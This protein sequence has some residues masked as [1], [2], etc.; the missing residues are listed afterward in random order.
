MHLLLVF[1]PK[2]L[3]ACPKPVAAPASDILRAIRESARTGVTPEEIIAKHKHREPHV[4]TALTLNKRTTLPRTRNDSSVSFGINYNVRKAPTVDR[5]SNIVSSWS[6][7]VTGPSHYPL[8]HQS[9]HPSVVMRPSHHPVSVTQQ[10][11][12][13]VAVNA[14]PRSDSSSSTSSACSYRTHSDVDSGSLREKVIQLKQELKHC[15]E[16]QEE[17]QQKKLEANKRC[18]EAKRIFSE[19]HKKLAAANEKLE[20]VLDKLDKAEHR[21]LYLERRK[22]ENIQEKEKLEKEQLGE[23]REIKNVQYEI[24]EAKSAKE[25]TLQRLRE[26][27]QRVSARQLALQRAEGRM[28]ARSKRAKALED[29]IGSFRMKIRNLHVNKAK[30]LAKSEDQTHRLHLLEH[31]IE[32][33]EERS[34]VAEGRL[35]PL[36]IYTNQLQD[37]VE[38]RRE[39]LSKAQ[40][41]L[42]SYTQRLRHYRRYYY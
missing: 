5:N 11:Q 25:L 39:S 22:S 6:N 12:Q 26:V 38:E 13:P 32:Y 28:R 4:N 33:N 36:K 24:T 40:R 8:L 42:A 20:R 30:K 10:S 31:S 2:S 34:R 15:N 18:Q 7:G 3:H 14:R 41:Q 29:V 27:S 16:R 1:Q 23:E 9:H 35:L 19:R 37:A 17:D 21:L